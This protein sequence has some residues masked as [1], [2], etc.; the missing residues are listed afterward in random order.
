MPMPH[1]GARHFCSGAGLEPAIFGSYPS[2]GK[3]ELCANT[4]RRDESK[5]TLLVLA[6]MVATPCF[7][8]KYY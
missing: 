5:W 3:Y 1:K 6:F 4:L 7:D 8:E 2:S